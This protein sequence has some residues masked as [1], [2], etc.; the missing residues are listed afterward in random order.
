MSGLGTL[1]KPTT[2]GKT[3]IVVD[4][5]IENLAGTVATSGIILGMYYG[6]TGGST[7]AAMAALTGIALG[8]TL[9]SE[10]GATITA[11]DWWK[12]FSLT[13]FA[14]LSPGTQYW[15]DL[16]NVATVNSAKCAIVNPEWTIVELP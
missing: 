12:A 7:P 6:P 4:G 8:S 9:R 14:Q 5:S 13:R 2:T 10:A 1:F 16:A 15:F 3:L 11:T